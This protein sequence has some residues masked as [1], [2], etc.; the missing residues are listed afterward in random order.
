[1]TT[2]K[3]RCLVL[4][5]SGVLG[6]QLCR[7][8]L[9]NGARLAFTYFNNE[10]AA[11]SLKKSYPDSD[12]KIF[13][14]DARDLNELDSVVVKAVEELGGLDALIH[15]IGIGVTQ[16]EADSNQHMRMT[17]ITPASWDEMFQINVRSLFFAAAAALPALKESAN[18]QIVLTGS[19]DGEK[20]VPSPIHYA[21]TKAAL[22]GLVRSMTKE[23][24]EFQIKVNMVTPGI[25]TDGVSR[26]LPKD[27]REEYKKHCGFKREGRPDEFASLMAWLAL[28]NTYITGRSIIVDGA[29]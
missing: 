10:D 21:S 12:V 26:T 6:Q 28:E 3:K 27:M 19:I 17:E 20:A 24:G 4:G 14:M 16:S 25:M 8:L 7:T 5:G 29:L 15:C 18:G 11:Q 1:M 22:G 2:D 9:D 23:L 13:K